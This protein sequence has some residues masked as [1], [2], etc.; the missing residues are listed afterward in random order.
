MFSGRANSSY[1]TNDVRRVT[2]KRH[3]SVVVHVF[4]PLVIVLSVVVQCTS[5]DLWSL[6]CP[7]LFSVRLLNFG[8]CCSRLLTFDH[9]IVRRC[10]RL[11]TFGHCIVRRCSRL[12]TFGH[13]IV[14]RCSR[15]LRRR[16]QRRTIQW[17]K[18]RRR[19]QRWTIQWP[20]VRRREQR[21]TI[22]WPKVR[23]HTLFNDRQYNELSLFDLQL[24]I[25]SLVSFG[26]CIVCT[27]LIYSFWLPLWY[28]LAIVLS[29][30]VWF[31][32]S[33][34]DR[35]HNGQKIPK[36]YSEAVNQTRT[37]NTMAKRYQRGNQKL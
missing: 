13:C 21:Q 6:Y 36:R 17:S 19:E 35:Q 22:Q 5:S 16:E 2:V 10:S 29:V 4:W 28:L 27:C 32:A 34:K 26:H 30:L 37:D 25:T 23:R 20:K 18:V 24:L 1:F 33:N 8:H 9:C 31:T 3:E 7:S 11:L 14:R 12:L 15:L